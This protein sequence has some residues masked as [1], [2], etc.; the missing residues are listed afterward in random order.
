MSLTVGIGPLTK[1][2]QG[3]LNADLAGAPKH[4]LY[5]H[6]FGRHIRGELA[7]ESIVDS[8]GVM[9]LHETG[10]RPQLYFPLADIRS[11]VLLES[12]HKTHCP[13][14]GDARYWHLRVG[15]RLVENAVWS[16]PAPLPGAPDIAGLAGFYFDK[17]DAWY[18]E[19]EKILGHARDPFHRVDARRSHRH[20]TVTAGGRKIAETD[21]PIALFETGLPV[22]WYIPRADLDWSV[23]SDSDTHTVCP[24][25]GTA[26]YVSAGEQPD[27]GWTY[28]DPFDEAR[29]IADHYSFDGRGVEVSVGSYE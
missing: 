12:D 28:P 5:V 15:D 27:I 17:I 29:A 18:E 1:P 20:V 8:D 7:G 2:L 24:Y 4:L 14:K 23:L 13:Y 22:R 9:M 21:S 3:Q 26:S 6:E 25:K 19:D 10:L 11:D 16:Y